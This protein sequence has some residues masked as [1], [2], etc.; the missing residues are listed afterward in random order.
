MLLSSREPAASPA[1]GRKR[2]WLV[3][4]KAVSL[5]GLISG[6]GCWEC[7]SALECLP[8]VL[9]NFYCH[10]DTTEIYWVIAVQMGLKPCL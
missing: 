5:L 1:E 8:G 6:R 7:S 4:V 10:L 9:V 3:S 2:Q